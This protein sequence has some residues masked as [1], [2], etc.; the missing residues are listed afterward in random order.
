MISHSPPTI[1]RVKLSSNDRFITTITLFA[2]EP[3]DSERA[4]DGA[5]YRIVSPGND[6]ELG[7]TDDISLAPAAVAYDAVTNSV[8]V[9]PADKKGRLGLNRLFEIVVSSPASGGAA[10][11]TDAAGNSLDGDRDG[12]TGGS[13]VARLGRGNDRLTYRDRTGDTVSLAINRGIMDLLLG[14]DGE[15]I[16]LNLHGGPGLSTLTSRVRSRSLQP[17]TTTLRL[18]SGTD[19][20]QLSLP[21]AGFQIDQFSVAAL[22]ELLVSGSLT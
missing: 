10:G 12:A 13:Y 21:L 9:T 16:H 8:L 17:S 2:S 20:I 15:A 4:V 1:D 11:L 22:D 5:N 3:L 14:A 19:G 18:L 7:T 6:R